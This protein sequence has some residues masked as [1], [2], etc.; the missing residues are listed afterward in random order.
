MFA[1]KG[2]NAFAQCSLRSVSTFFAE[3]SLLFRSLLLAHVFDDNVAILTL[4]APSDIV[5][6]RLLGFRLN[7]LYIL[8]YC[9]YVLFLILSFLFQLYPDPCF[10]ATERP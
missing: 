4:Q 10:L 9:L 2:L 5:I 1:T 6:G 7:G 8:G 3:Y